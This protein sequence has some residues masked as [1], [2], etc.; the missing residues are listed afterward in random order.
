MPDQWRTCDPCGKSFFARIDQDR[1]TKFCSERCERV[2]A[3]Y[4]PAGTY[5]I[6]QGC[7]VIFLALERNYRR[8]DDCHRAN[9][10]KGNLAK[11]VH[12]SERSGCGSS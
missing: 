10:E 9:T 4:A 1:A 11:A 5:R 3:M 2:G 6:C 7:S 12:G 8:C